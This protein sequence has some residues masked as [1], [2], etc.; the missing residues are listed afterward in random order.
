[1][2]T[3]PLRMWLALFTQ[4]RGRVRLSRGC[5]RVAAA[6]KYGA[7]LKLT[8]LCWF[9]LPEDL[10]HSFCISLWVYTASITW[11]TTS[12][13]YKYPSSFP[14][15][16]EHLSTCHTATGR[17]VAL[18]HWGNEHQGNKH[19][20][21]QWGH[22]VPPAFSEE[23]HSFFCCWGKCRGPRQ[24]SQEAGSW[25]AE[26]SL[27]SVLWVTVLMPWVQG[28]TWRGSLLCS[29]RE[30]GIS[31]RDWNF[32]SGAFF[33]RFLLGVKKKQR[34]LSWSTVWCV[35]PGREASRSRNSVL[36]LSVV[37]GFW[38]S[39]WGYWLSLVC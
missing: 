9:T 28:R 23:I 22:L 12:D 32:R 10:M 26:A 6:Q 24:S 20:R 14:L 25:V 21:P 33:T 13:F 15:T 39:V 8:G 27:P 19:C 34:V 18:G 29:C 1:M 37:F 38:I 30:G 35:V 31:G 36:L 7:L 11:L 5:G 2:L 16:A 4:P 17:S 3:T